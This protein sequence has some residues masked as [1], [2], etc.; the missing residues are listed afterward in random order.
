MKTLLQASFPVDSEGDPLLGEMAQLGSWGCRV[1]LFIDGHEVTGV[2]L[3]PHDYL[4]RLDRQF[5]KYDTE[6]GSHAG[7]MR[8]YI[9]PSPGE[10]FAAGSYGGVEGYAAPKWIHL[11]EA[12][13]THGDQTRKIG[14]WRGRLAEVSGW[15]L[16]SPRGRDA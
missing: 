2:I 12:T 4:H 10:E 14:L 13:A 8:D 15:T 3:S 6:M 5:A 16:R 9:A 1:T 7:A 11:A